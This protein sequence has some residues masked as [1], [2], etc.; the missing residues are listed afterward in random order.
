M[1][2]DLIKHCGQLIPNNHKKETHG[3]K[4]I[5]ELIA[6]D[7]YVLVNSTDKVVGGPFTRYSPDDPHNDEKKSALDLIIV[8]KNLYK[9]IDKLEMD[10]E[11][12]WTPC[13]SVN[14]S[15]LNIQTII[16]CFLCSKGCQKRQIK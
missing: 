5:K 10:K 3:G 4:H 9:Y 7:K 13:Y 16:R 12:K 11:R 8:S 14:K 1:V 6:D 2:G 15:S